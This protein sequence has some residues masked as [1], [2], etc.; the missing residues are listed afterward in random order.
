MARK[1]STFLMLIATTAVAGAAFADSGFITGHHEMPDTGNNMH[2]EGEMLAHFEHLDK[3]DDGKVTREE[4]AVHEGTMKMF[5]KM[6][7]DRMGKDR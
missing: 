4:M 6:A 3:N 5:K 7:E 2:L 1:T